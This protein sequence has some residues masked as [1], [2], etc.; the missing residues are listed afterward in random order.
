M[1]K[2]VKDKFP[3]VSTADIWAMAGLVAVE[4]TG[5]PAVDVKL[6]R[7]DKTE[8]EGGVPPNGRLPDATQVKESTQFNLLSVV[9]SFFLFFCVALFVIMT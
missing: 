4:V 3:G 1:L 9:S 8:E 6:G 2:P 5:G 7:S